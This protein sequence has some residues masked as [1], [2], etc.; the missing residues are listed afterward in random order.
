MTQPSLPTLMLVAGPNGCG[1]STL[2]RMVEFGELQE[3]DD[4]DDAIERG[5]SPSEAA[6]ETLRQRRRALLERQSFLVETTLSGAGIFRL[7]EAARKD[8]YMIV[9]HYI[10]L[11]SS[12]QALDRIGNRVERGGHNVP[13]NVVRRRF[14]RSRSNLPTAV[15]LADEV[16][17]YDNSLTDE[18]PHKVVMI[19]KEKIWRV[20]VP[21]WAAPVVD[22]MALS[23]VPIIRL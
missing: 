7:M 13:K 20:S 16:F 12:K 5:M 9:L 2:A 1:K 6:R 19:F 17:F 22:A 10:L 15:Q 3:I 11:G 4:P 8:G 18:R 21:H 14:L 23:S